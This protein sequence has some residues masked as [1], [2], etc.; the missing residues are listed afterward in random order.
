[1]FYHLARKNKLLVK[2]FNDFKGL[3]KENE[4]LYEYYCYKL[5]SFSDQLFVCLKDI[6][7]DENNRRQAKNVILIR[8]F[9]Q[10]FLFVCGI[11]YLCVIGLN[12]NLI[13]VSSARKY[14]LKRKN[15]Q[16]A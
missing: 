9:I 6:N 3:F 13:C 1:M 11:I 15:Y 8:C 7:I 10:F 12:I 4:W 2:K 5:L 16:A 14:I